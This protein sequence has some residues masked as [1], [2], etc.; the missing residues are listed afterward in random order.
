MHLLQEAFGDSVGSCKL[1]YAIPSETNAQTQQAQTSVEAG[2]SRISAKTAARIAQ[3][4]P[5]RY[6]IANLDC[7]PYVLRIYMCR[8]TRSCHR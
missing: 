1:F 4:A 3:W 7:N 8:R 5:L 2:V 6:H